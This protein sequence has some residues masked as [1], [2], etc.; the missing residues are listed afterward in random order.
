MYILA[1]SV[2]VLHRYLPVLQT[3]HLSKYVHYI[4]IGKKTNLRKPLSFAVLADIGQTNDS[5]RTIQ[6]ILEDPSIKM[7]LHAGIMTFARRLVLLV[8]YI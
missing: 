8:T 6:H 2:V 7:V 1:A 5:V 3:N 4:Y